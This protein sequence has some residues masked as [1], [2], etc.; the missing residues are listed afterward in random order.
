MRCHN[1]PG[2]KEE[3]SQ[4]VKSR[5]HGDRL[6]PYLMWMCSTCAGLFVKAFNAQPS[7]VSRL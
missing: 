7:D 6:A 1:F 4:R 2:C 3:A 5:Y